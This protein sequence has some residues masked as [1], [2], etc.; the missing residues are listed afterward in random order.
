M[1]YMNF[2]MFEMKYLSRA[3]QSVFALAVLGLSACTS[4]PLT[5]LPRL[6]GLNP[7]QMDFSEV[8]VA[9]RVQE[10]FRLEK[11][12][13]TLSMDLTN[14][15]Q[16]LDLSEQFPLDIRQ[17]DD[18]PFL[19]RQAKPGFTIYEFQ[20]RPEDATR[21]RKLQAVVADLKRRSE[22]GETPKE[23]HSFS[24][25]VNFKPCLEK[26][27]NPFRNARVTVYLRPDPA[28]AYFKLVK[29]RKFDMAGDTIGQIKTCAGD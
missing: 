27:A 11:D 26:G 20:I 22:S 24:L 10:G 25:S 15:T 6:Q 18:D 5:S 9:L 4:V 3:S 7:T 14:E 19:N 29:E 23:K 13:V 12:T 28:D 21:A 1:Y 17:R 2:W 8:R 16:W